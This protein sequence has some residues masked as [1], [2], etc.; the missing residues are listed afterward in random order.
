MTL[1]QSCGT[2]PRGATWGPNDTI[3]MAT[4]DPTSGLLGSRPLVVNRTC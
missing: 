3:V 2:G 1:C 4:T